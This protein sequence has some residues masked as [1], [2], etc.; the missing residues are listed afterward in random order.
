[1]NGGASLPRRSRSALDL[2]AWEVEGAWESWGAP[3]EK[4]W[5]EGSSDASDS[6][7]MNYPATLYDKVVR[8]LKGWYS[9]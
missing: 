7:N 3:R 8:T 6:L 2:D 4:E 5:E 1:M 9:V